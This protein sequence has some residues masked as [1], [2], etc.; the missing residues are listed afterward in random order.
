MIPLY[1]VCVGLPA[2]TGSTR[3][4]PPFRRTVMVCAAAFTTLRWSRPTVK[5]TSLDWMPRTPGAPSTPRSRRCR[6]TRVPGRQKSAG[7]R[8]SRRSPN[9][10][11]A[12]STGG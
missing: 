1:V 12:T 5:P 6:V 9:Q 4:T 8:S 7:R 11:P 10:C 2:E 3:S